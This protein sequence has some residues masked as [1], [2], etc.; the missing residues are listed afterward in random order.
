MMQRNKLIRNKNICIFGKENNYWSATL[1]EIL[2]VS[3]NEVHFYKK[4]SIDF[5]R[6]TATL[7]GQPHER[8]NILKRLDFRA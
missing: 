6:L 5:S 4:I 1:Q 3:P 8:G 2:S 7:R